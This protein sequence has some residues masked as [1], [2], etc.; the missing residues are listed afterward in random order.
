MGMYQRLKNWF[1]LNYSHLGYDLTPYYTV[2]EDLI[3]K[4]DILKFGR[5][6]EIKELNLEKITDFTSANP[7]V[8]KLLFD[9]LFRQ[10]GYRIDNDFVPLKQV[11][12][13]K[14]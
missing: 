13:F 8:K 9:A 4:F 3:P 5:E 1:R 14:L 10:H 12:E 11:K 2:G 7:E 6:T